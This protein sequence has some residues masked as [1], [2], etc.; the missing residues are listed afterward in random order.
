MPPAKVRI[1]QPRPGSKAEAILTLT[2][3][4]PATPP[5]I[6]Q[7]VNTSRQMVHQVLDRYG[8]EPNTLESYKNSRADIYAAAQL[9]ILAAVD[10]G[11]INVET[12]RDVRDAMTGLGILVDKERL[13][14]GQA[15]S[16][17]VY[18]LSDRL[19]AALS[20]SG[21]RAE[22]AQVEGGAG[23]IIDIDPEAAPAGQ[24]SEGVKTI[25]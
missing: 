5:Q 8:I 16:R 24:A 18:D 7:H 15:T 11:A 21:D 17:I 12:A 3:T 1:R 13:E 20:R 22:I 10:M 14:R 19:R 23:Q 4:T 9:K 2:A 6:A 25:P